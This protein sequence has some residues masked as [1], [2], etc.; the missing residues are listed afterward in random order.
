MRHF[1]KIALAMVVALSLSSD[2]L[3]K[4]P[5]KDKNVTPA[6]TE[7]PADAKAPA[8]AAPALEIQTTGIADVDNVFQQAVDPLNNLRNARNALDSLNTNLVTVLGLP[9]GTP[10]ADALNDLKAKAEGKIT[11]AIDEKGMPK[12]SPS[13]AVP[14]NV[15]NAINAVNQGVTDVMTAVE[16]LAQLPSQMKEIAAAAT[17]IS[18]DSLISSGVKPLEAPKLMKTVN[19]NIKVV[20]EAPNEL[21]ALKASLESTIGTLKST[22]GA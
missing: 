7:Q 5:K 13:D 4:K 15:S 17:A 8:E 16:S 21:T 9:A 12:L 11:M 14:E 18:P 6:D 20:G 3:A 19:G 22:F 2:A 1:M 10:I